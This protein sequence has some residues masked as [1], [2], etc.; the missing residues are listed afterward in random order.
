[1]KEFLKYFVFAD[2]LL[3]LIL[4]LVGGIWAVSEVLLHIPV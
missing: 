3:A 2:I 1:M 4:I